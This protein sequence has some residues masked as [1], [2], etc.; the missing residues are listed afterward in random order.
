MFSSNTVSIQATRVWFPVGPDRCVC[1][2]PCAVSNDGLTFCWP[3]CR[4][5][6]SCTFC[7]VS[8]ILKCH[9]MTWI[10]MST[11]QERAWLLLRGIFWALPSCTHLCL[12]PPSSSLCKRL[13]GSRS[14]VCSSVGKLDPLRW[15]PFLNYLIFRVSCKFWSLVLLFY[16]VFRALGWDVW[17]RMT[18]VY[19]G[20]L[21]HLHVHFCPSNEP[22]CFQ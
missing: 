15:E 22:W 12:L 8:L 14:W 2:L 10:F 19:F 11:Q 7:E 21:R 9:R 3:L 13:P 1:P 18:C 20:V 16:N 17:T 5:W 6:N 4:N